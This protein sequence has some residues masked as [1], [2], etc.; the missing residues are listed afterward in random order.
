MSD[1]AKRGTDD[2]DDACGSEQGERGRRGKRGPRGR[3]GHEGHD[4]HDGATGPTG[5]AGSSSTGATGST[6]PAGS[7]SS[8]G[9]TG[10]TGPTGTSGDTGPAGSPGDTGPIGPTGSQ[11]GTGPIGPTGSQGPTGPAG[12]GG[13]VTPSTFN[14]VD[15]A[16]ENATVNVTTEGTLD[17]YALSGAPQD[18]VSNTSVTHAKAS[19]GKIISLMQLARGGNG[20]PAVNGNAGLSIVA[21]G[22]LNYRVTTNGPDTTATSVLT[23]ANTCGAIGDSTTLAGIGWIMRIPVV[24]GTSG[25]IR[26]RGGGTARLLIRAWTTDG[27][28][29]QQLNYASVADYIW[30][31]W[32]LSFVAGSNNS[33]V[34]IELLTDGVTAFNNTPTVHLSAV[35]VAPV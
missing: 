28:P 23:A 21:A 18:R 26:V 35:T 6:G 27:A 32:T 29:V 30:Q 33:E 11:G 3:A 15:G 24:A 12:S 10:S 34:V 5:P 2:S 25:V 9:A 7:P 4:G 22:S 31:K 14:L 16:C 17:W 13:S 1:I 20:A 8:T 19:A